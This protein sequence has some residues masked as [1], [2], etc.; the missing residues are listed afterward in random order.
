LRK[1]DTR[2]GDPLNLLLR[3]D[4]FV[5]RLDHEQPFTG[6]TRRWRG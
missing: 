2:V 3:H 4:S 6:R 1:L 5:R